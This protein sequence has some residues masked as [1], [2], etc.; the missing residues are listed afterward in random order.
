VWLN[1]FCRI[2][3]EPGGSGKPGY[4]D[5]SYNFIAKAILEAI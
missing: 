2:H 5:I 1:K 4:A 3:P